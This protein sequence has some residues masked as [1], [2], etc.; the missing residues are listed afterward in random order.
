MIAENGHSAEIESRRGAVVDTHD[1]TTAALLAGL[2]AA[3]DIHADALRPKNTTRGYASDW[4]AWQAFIA[5]TNQDLA[6]PAGAALAE[7]LG[8][9]AGT[10][11]QLPETATSRGLL[12]A[13]VTTLWKAGAAPT[14]ID[15]R[16]SGLVVTLRREHQV[17]V[18]PDHVKAARELLKDYVRTAAEDREAPRG[19]GQAAPLL[20]PDLRKMSAA[21][22]DTLAGIRDR[23]LVL[24]AFAIAGRR[25][26]VAGLTVRDVVEAPEGLVVDVRVS[27]TK[28]RT[29]A[30]PYGSNPQT[31][32]V[33]AWQAWRTAAALEDD[34]PAFRAVDRHGR[35]GGALSGQAAGDVVTRA[36]ERA[37]AETKLTG[38]SPR[39][40]LATEARRAGK[41]RKAIAATTGH[42][43]NSAVLDGYIRSVDR[44]DGDDNALIG[45]GL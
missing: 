27:K 30:V 15:R 41:D 29:V 44:W 32:P 21:C 8:L 23:A 36:G 2:D 24:L 39:A 13:Y 12:R 16:L 34:S 5:A 9:E 37:G 1:Q 33:R 26:E 22:P 10:Q 11:L 6:G 7:Q 42:V 18:N 17:M 4:K 35:I 3:S 31:C 28:P 45:I 43:P 20:L 14:T 19:R 40:G 38:H 25:S